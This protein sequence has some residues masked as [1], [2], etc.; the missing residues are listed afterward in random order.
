MVKVLGVTSGVGERF[1]RYFLLGVILVLIVFLFL[2]AI[3]F[4]STLFVSAVIAAATLPFRKFLRRQTKLTRTLSSLLTL[5]LLT[6]LVILPGSLLVI[7][8]INQAS[9]A[10]QT[11][12]VHFSNFAESGY[13]FLPI[14]DRY[15]D[16]QEWIRGILERNQISSQD[17]LAKIGEF[18]TFLSR[19]IL[20]HTPD[21]VRFASVFIVHGIVFLLG[22]YYFIRD[23]E[24][25]ASH[26][27]SLLP[28]SEEHRKLLFTRIYDLMHAI[29]YGILGAAL[30]Q[31]LILWMGLQIAGVNNA[32][33]W[34]ALGAL[35]SPLPYIGVGVIWAPIVVSLFAT[36]HMGA[37]TFLLIWCMTAVSNVDNILKPY[38]IGS[39]TSLHPLALLVV[40]L[41]GAFTFGIKGLIFGPFILTLF[42][43]FLEIYRHEYR[44]VLETPED[45]ERMRKKLAAK[46]K[47]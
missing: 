9:I 7:Y 8:I 33:F 12:M 22:L 35:F 15:P 21:I 32:L 19:S 4:L 13:N 36:Q 16:L 46:K 37:G 18:L 43:V 10:Y 40:I 14:L 34:A 5:L 30:A 1:R 39:K 44:R 24:K 42:L 3:D 31:G 23:G 27:R 17:I 38:L 20:S 28:L 45:K 29:V 6:V 25:I 26:I 47:K 41:G 2:F 11:V